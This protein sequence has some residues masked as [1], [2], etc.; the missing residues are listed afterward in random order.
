MK[1]KYF[2]IDFDETLFNH[3]AY[4]DWLTGFLQDAY[5]IDTGDFLSTFDEYHEV[6]D[7]KGLLRL[8]R[9]E[10][11]ILEQTGLTWPK[12]SGEIEHQVQAENRHFCYPDAHKFLVEAAVGRAGK[13]RLLTYGDEAYQRYKISLCRVVSHLPVHVVSTPKSV[14]LSEEYGGKE[15]SGILID[16]KYPLDLPANWQHVWLNR[17]NKKLADPGAIEVSSL[18]L[19]DIVASVENAGTMIG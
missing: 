12:I 11:H 9:H 16:D 3:R 1:H 5:G 6:K 4:V 15:V 13:V 8:Y 7:E 19:A 2:F 14:F 10:Q 17:N 18:D